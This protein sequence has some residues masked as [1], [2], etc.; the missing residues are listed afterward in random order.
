M[1]T[2][3]IADEPAWAS[4]RNRWT[5]RADTIYLNHGS[6]GPPP[7]SVQQA[8]RRWQRRVD[9]N[10]MD[11]FF[12]HLEHELLR[13]RAQLAAFVGT[14][15]E[16]LV[17]VDNATYGMNVVANSFSLAEGDEV[18]LTDHEYGAIRRI[19]QRRCEQAGAQLRTAELPRPIEA[20]D[21]ILDAITAAF[22]RATRL[23]VV[24]HITSPTA[25]TLPVAEIAKAA[26][27]RN[28]AVC[29]D[30]PHAVAQLPLE[31]DA[32]DCDFYTASCHK[33]LCAPFG[34]GFLYVHPRHHEAMQPPVLSWGRIGAR[35][36]PATW[37]DEF[38]WLGTR[39]PSAALAIPA[40]IAELKR[41][42]LDA[43]RARTHYLAAHARARLS[44]L[45][46][47]R[48]LVPDQVTWHGAMAHA[49][50]PPGEAR[51]LQNALWGRFGIEVP[52]IEF[53]GR[54]WIRVSCHLYTQ[55]S[56]IDTLIDALGALL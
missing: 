31:I 44:E 47:L 45:T 7:R 16:N 20:A 35:D 56:D 29:I 6:F 50:L 39:D 23:L 32:L 15:T 37:D 18:L 25:I 41:V 27:E 13:V 14:Q 42:G 28:I 11:F 19:W 54:R 8:R 3:I 1:A 53:A 30:G 17:L 46:G 36:G 52:I 21:Q 22:T 38:A 24:S 26:R 5:I 48:P 9:A 55:K 49:P 2:P 12:R 33:W 10:P 4:W 40:A 43:F 34:T 51:P